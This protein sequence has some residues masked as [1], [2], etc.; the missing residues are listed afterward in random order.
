M[1]KSLFFALFVLFLATISAFAQENMSCSS[2][3]QGI[4][5]CEFSDGRANITTTIGSNVSSD[6][7]SPEDWSKRGP[8]L[9]KQWTDAIRAE[10]DAL[11]AQAAQMHKD[12]VIDSYGKRY[13]Q[14]HW[15]CDQ[16]GGK[17]GEMRHNCK[18]AK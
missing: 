12:N 18:L 10:A 16:A 5:V 8:E 7:Y 3:V 2:P 6:W 4:R 14:K 17:W 9:R 13:G 15:D 11:N 1:K